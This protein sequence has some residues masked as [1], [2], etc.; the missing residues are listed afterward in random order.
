MRAWPPL[1]ILIAL[2][3]LG[4]SA[5]GLSLVLGG[6]SGAPES[7][8]SLLADALPTGDARTKEIRLG[9]ESTVPV[10]LE[11]VEWGSQDI[12]ISPAAGTSWSLRV[13][14]TGESLLRVLGSGPAE[15]LPFALRVEVDAPGLPIRREIRWIETTP[16]R[17]VIHPRS[18]AAGNQ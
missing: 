18:A 14:S 5:L 2:G 15:N 1:Q 13:E 3:F 4:I 8:T 7:K 10:R 9:L 12:S 17:I 6:R 16:F 11:S